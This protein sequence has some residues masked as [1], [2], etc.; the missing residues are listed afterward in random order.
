M[1]FTDPHIVSTSSDHRTLS[2][3]ITVSNLDTTTG[4][5]PR[6]SSTVDSLESAIGLSG[7]TATGPE[8]STPSPSGSNSDATSIVPTSTT[9]SSTSG[10]EWRY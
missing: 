6:D 5:G 3:A 2:T 7:S 4:H 8:V 1:E 10:T 9:V